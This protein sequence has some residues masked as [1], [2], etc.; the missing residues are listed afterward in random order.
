M[1]FKLSD[2]NEKTQRK[3]RDQLCNDLRPVEARQPE[4]AV[5]SA[6]DSCLKESKQSTNRVAIS[7]VFVVLLRRVMDSDNLIGS[8]KPCRDAVC[9]SLGIDDG[10]E[11]ITFEY[12]QVKTTGSEGVIVKISV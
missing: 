7:I 6:L 12:H 9:E 4:P 2:F 10:D 11:R 1:G 3:I 5:A 8:L